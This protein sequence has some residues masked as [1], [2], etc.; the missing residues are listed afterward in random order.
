LSEKEVGVGWIF[1]GANEEGE[2]P[3]VFHPIIL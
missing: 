2:N 1:C 3:R